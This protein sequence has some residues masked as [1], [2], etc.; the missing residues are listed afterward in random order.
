MQPSQHTGHRAVRAGDIVPSAWLGRRG[1]VAALS[2]ASLGLLAL[3]PLAAATGSNSDG[4]RLVTSSVTTKHTL[5]VRASAD[6]EAS[7]A[8]RSHAY[9]AGSRLIGRTGSGKSKVS[10][11]R[12]TVTGLPASARVT[13]TD[14][15]LHRDTHHLSGRV[16]LHRVTSAWSESTLTWK[17]R[18]T[19][20]ALVS[21]RAL[22]KAT[23]TVTF[24]SGRPLKGN[25]TV[26][27]AIT[28]PNRTDPVWFSSREAGSTGPKLVVHYETTTTTKAAAPTTPAPTQTSPAP[29][30][31]PTTSAPTTAPSDSP[32]SSS[33]PTTGSTP[34]ST[35]TS[36]SRCDLSALLVPQC[37]VLW[38]AIPAAFTTDARTP[39]TAAF[40]SEMG[41]PMDVYHQYHANGSLFPNAEERALAAGGAGGR[42][43]LENW[44]PA[45]DY[46]WR[47]VA[48]G[49]VDSRIDTEA[50]YIE[51][52][53]HKKFFLTIWHEPENDVIATAGSGM[54][55][56]DYS[57]MF[58]HTILRLRA[59][60]VTNAVIVM[61]YMGDPTWSTT[62]WFPD[63]WPG[64]DVVDWIGWDPYACFPGKA[65]GDFAGMLN[66][67]YVKNGTYNGFYNWATTTHPG[68]PLM[69]SEWGVFEN[70]G[71]VTRKADFIKTVA[72]ELGQF[73]ALKAMVYFDSPH[74]SHGSGAINSSPEAL[75]A[76][77][78]LS[79]SLTRFNLP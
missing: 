15:V 20:G 68:V 23:N 19:T 21:S 43:L 73:P 54:T 33:A 74:A 56:A 8:R 66:R 12:F 62:S 41:R 42:I 70:G 38:G 78:Q 6:T 2:A 47:Q 25:G 59:D 17:T 22:T 67:V 64:N 35:S 28:S 76:Y 61:N 46:T 63:L 77:Q 55:A 51:A 60:G 14:V 5:T 9:G 58:R 10:Y 79:A 1:G 37:G 32:T 34:S 53:F 4:I 72:P 52:N 27:F 48:D 36:S 29:T 39:A 40:E 45:T 18:P 26:S 50:A 13:S 44:K 49:A 31:Q 30:S 69:L 65:C 16:H 3:V 11:V 75:S 71:D 24:A 7:Q 57:A